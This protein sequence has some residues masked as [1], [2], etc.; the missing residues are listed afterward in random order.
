MCK[1]NLG[2]CKPREN[3]TPTSVYLSPTP[4]QFEQMNCAVRVVFSEERYCGL[5]VCVP[6]NLA[7]VSPGAVVLRVG[8]LGGDQVVG[9]PSSGGQRPVTET[10]GSSL[11]L[12][13]SKVSG[14]SYLKP[15]RVTGVPQ[16]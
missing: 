12:R 16:N 14:T 6:P 11:A 1:I 10:L 2:A 13:T 5:Q 8:P 4:E 3:S 9:A 15:R 7:C